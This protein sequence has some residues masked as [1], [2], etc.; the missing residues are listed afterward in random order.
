[1]MTPTLETKVHEFLAQKRIAVVG[2]SRDHSHHP[3][4]SL[5][6]RRLKTSGHDVFPVNPHMQ[7][8]DG[9]R[10]YP[11]VQ[12]IPGGVDGVVIV[13]RPEVTEQI[14]HDCSDARIGRV[15][16]HES[17]GVKGSSVSPAA[18][19]YCRHHNISVIAGACPMMFGPRA[20]F[21][22]T[23]MR[24]FLELTGRLPA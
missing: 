6:Y 9:D 15:W 11:D 20:D 12:S 3:A 7:A 17:V 19:E 2:V 14:V 16:I 10:C 18:A 4:G 22:H 21:A 5:I 13:T 23:C 24:W 8:F 1:M